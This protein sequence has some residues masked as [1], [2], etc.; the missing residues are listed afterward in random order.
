MF[1]KE[2]PFFCFKIGITG[3]PEPLVPLK[4]I[5][6]YYSFLTFLFEQLELYCTAT[7]ETGV[8]CARC[9]PLDK[10]FG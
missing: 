5:C 4:I 1:F 8:F 2:D 10:G 9:L 3:I 7:V 6:S